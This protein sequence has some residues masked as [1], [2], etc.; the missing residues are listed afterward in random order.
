[1]PKRAGGVRPVA[2]GSVLRRLAAR[3]A[4]LALK[5]DIA[6]AVGPHQFAVGVAGGCEKVQKTLAAAT[7]ARP[8]AVV[9]ALDFTNAYNSILRSVIRA[10]VRRRLS[11]L[12]PL[13]ATVCGPESRHWFYDDAGGN[14][15]L[16]TRGVDQGCP[17]TYVW[18]LA[19]AG[20]LRG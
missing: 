1:M 2:C 15:I 13:V 14:A 3:G 7:E 19:N 17:L 8:E 10:A 11:E 18:S 20:F 6:S 12:A 5:E 4:C 9:L 16:S